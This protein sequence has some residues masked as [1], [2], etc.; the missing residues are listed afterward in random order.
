MRRVSHCNRICSFI[1]AKVH[2]ILS[3]NDLNLLQ[4]LLMAEV[5]DIGQGGAGM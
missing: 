3:V 2:L 5:V 1:I 4:L